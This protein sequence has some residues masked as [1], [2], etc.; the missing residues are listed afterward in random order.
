MK[1]NVVFQLTALLNIGENNQFLNDDGGSQK[2]TKDAIMD[3]KA[4]GLEGKVFSEFLF[5]NF[6]FPLKQLPTF[7]MPYNPT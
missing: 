5:Q 6:L 3:L 4:Q 7:Y 2:L 1:N